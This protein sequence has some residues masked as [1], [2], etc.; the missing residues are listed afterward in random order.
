M[1]NSFFD[2]M[3]KLFANILNNWGWKLAAFGVAL[4]IFYSIRS[5]TRHTQTLTLAVEAETIEGGQAL[6]GFEPAVVQVT[7]R[8]A[9]ADIRQLSLSGA[10]QPR[11]RLDLKQ[12]PAGASS[13]ELSLSHYDIIHADGLRVASIEPSTITALFDT[14]DTRSFAVDE[15]I[16]RGTPASGVAIVSIEPKMVELTGS[17]LLM[18][19]LESTETV[20]AVSSIDVS[21]RTE[22]F[23]TFLKVQPPDN[24]GGWTVRPDT[25]RADVKIVR[26]D[27]SRTFQKIPVRVLQS[28]SGKRY[29][30]EPRMAEVVVH[31]V[32]QDLNQIEPES[33]QLL[34]E[35]PEGQEPD[36]EEKFSCEP[37]VVLPCT[38]RVS[39]VT[40]TPETIWLK[41]VI[42]S[43]APNNETL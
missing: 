8:G 42:N 20:L 31:G 5:G 39:R 33:I 37:V 43:E 1:R 6:V 35:E 38:N 25:V 9:E 23:E 11:V 12:P 36:A 10:E 32:E 28:Y 7:F 30:P 27:I 17:K 26:S 3:R 18:D 2:S 40:V 14:R 19:E 4:V 21:G 24:R 15:P 13:I 34:I 29:H 16:L 41:P 22:G